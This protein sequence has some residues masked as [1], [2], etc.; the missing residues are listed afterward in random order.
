MILIIFLGNFF[1]GKS[2]WVHIF[3]CTIDWISFRSLKR[4]DC[5]YELGL[6]ESV[7]VGERRWVRF[8]VHNDSVIKRAKLLWQSCLVLH[9]RVVEIFDS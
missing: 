1:R 6:I 3:C 4:I 5:G 2:A 9:I 8:G 7:L